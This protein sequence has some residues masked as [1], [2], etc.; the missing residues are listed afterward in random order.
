[1]TQKIDSNPSIVP[2]LLRAKDAP[3]YLAMDRSLFKKLVEPYV[4]KRKTS[5][6]HVTFD[7]LELDAWVDNTR[8][9]YGRPPAP[10]TEIRRSTWDE[11]ALPASQSV[12][13]SG[14]LKKKYPG[15]DAFERALAQASS[16]KRR[17]TSHAD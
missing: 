3:A 5:A 4:T 11:S 13:R 17:G 8:D 9:R 14:M 7:R 15:T 16:K 10:P 2:R 12:V 1:V 6:G